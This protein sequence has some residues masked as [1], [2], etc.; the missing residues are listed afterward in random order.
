[1]VGLYR[2][3]RQKDKAPD[4][5]GELGAV[6]MGRLIGETGPL[7]DFDRRRELQHYGG[8]NLYERQSGKYRGETKI[9]KAC[10]DYRRDR[11]YPDYRNSIQKRMV[12]TRIV[13]LI[14]RLVAVIHPSLIRSSLYRHR[15]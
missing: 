13:K 14:R 15:S 6:T 8:V 10:P 11:G 12:T 3:L 1:M 5:V 9:S 7:K 4:P 2:Q